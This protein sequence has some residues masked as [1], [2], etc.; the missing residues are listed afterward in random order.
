MKSTTG[1]ITSIRS[2]IFPERGIRVSWSFWL[3]LAVALLVSPQDVVLAVLLAAGMHECGH[4]L[5]LGACHVP[6]DGLRLNSAGAVLYARGARRLSYGRELFVTLAGPAVNL[7][8]APLLAAFSVRTGWQWGFLF[9]GAHVVLGVYNLLPIP[10]LDGARALYLLLSWR[11]GP[12]T[13]ET[14]STAAGLLA[15]CA[16]VCFGACLTF[17]HGGALFLLAAV[18]LLAGCARGVFPCRPFPGKSKKSP[19]I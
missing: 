1:R 4:A 14:V 16:L 13:G 17:A 5:A 2:T 11:W 15:S 8:A 19:G 12:E 18:G 7:T 10:P 9:A 3:L 6:L